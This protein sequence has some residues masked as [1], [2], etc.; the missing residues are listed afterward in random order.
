[1][2][3]RKFVPTVYE[4]PGP[5]ATTAAGD[6]HAPGSGYN[7]DFGHVNIDERQPV[8]ILSYFNSLVDMHDVTWPN[9]SE[10][11][12]YISR[13]DFTLKFKRIDSLMICDLLPYYQ[14]THNEP[15]YSS[16]NVTIQQYDTDEVRSLD[17]NFMLEYPVFN[18][19]IYDTEQVTPVP[20]TIAS[21]DGEQTGGAISEEPAPKRRRKRRKK[22]DFN[23]KGQELPSSVI[24]SKFMMIPQMTSKQVKALDEVHHALQRTWDSSEADLI[25]RL[26]NG[27]LNNAKFYPAD[28]RNYFKLFGRELGADKGRTEHETY[29][30][31]DLISRIDIFKNEILLRG[32][33]M[34]ICGMVFLILIAYPSGYATVSHVDSREGEVLG[35]EI[36]RA[37]KWFK[38]RGYTP[39]LLNFD[40]EPGVIEQTS[41][42]EDAGVE[43][44]INPHGVKVAEA[45]NLI[46]TIKQ[47]LR[48]KLA[49]L[50]YDVGKT[51]LVNL[52]IAAVA[53]TNLISKKTNIGMLSPHQALF[54]SSIN[55]DTMLRFSPNDYVE[56]SVDETINDVLTHRTISAI[57]LFA[58]PVNQS[59]WKFFNLKTCRT[60]HRHVDAAARRP[61]TAE[62]INRLNQIAELNPIKGKDSEGNPI[63]I[64]QNSDGVEIP[65]DLGTLDTIAADNSIHPVPIP[66]P[67]VLNPD[68]IR[69]DT[70]VPPET[71]DDHRLGVDISTVQ[72]D[73]DISS[74]QEDTSTAQDDTAPSSSSIVPVESFSSRAGIEVRTNDTISDALAPE[75]DL[76]RVNPN[77][78]TE[79]TR[80]LRSSYGRV[81]NKRYF[82]T[83]FIN[84]TYIDP[85][86]Y[87][88][89]KS[90]FSTHLSAA[91]ALKIHSD[92][93]LN[94]ITSEIQGMVDREVF[95]GV[96]RSDLSYNQQRK[97]IRSSMF[98]KEK[99][100]SVGRL[101]KLK[102]RLVAG[103][104]RQD[105]SIYT[106]DQIS[107]PTV[108][109]ISF[110]TLAA[111]SAAE[112]RHILTFDIGQAYLNAD[113]EGEVYMVL[114]RLTASILVDIDP[115]YKQYLEKNGSMLVKLSKA[116]YGC[117]ESAKL[118][119][120]HLKAT[121]I[122]LGYTVNPVD[123]CVFNRVSDSGA[124]S[125]VCFHVDD[126]FASCESLEDLKLLEKQLRK[127]F[128]HVEIHHGKVHEYLGMKLDFTEKYI[129]HITMQAYIKR[130]IDDNQITKSS[131]TPAGANL[132]VVDE[133]SEK[134]D[135]A[136]SD[137]FHKVT[138][139]LLYL[140]TR[141]RP[142]IL[143]PTTFLCSRV[144]SPTVEDVKKLTR[145]LMYLNRTPNLGIMIGGD[146]SGNFRLMTYADAS[147]ATHPDGMKSHSGILLSI[148]RGPVLV[149]SSK[150]KLVT[151][152]STEA[153]LV[154]LSDATS[155]SIHEL[156]FLKA[157]GIE[158][159]ANLMQDNTSTIKLAENGRSN[160]DRTRHIK[161]RYFFIKQF[162][163][164]GE[165]K[166]S[167]CPTMH[168]VADILTKPLQG[169]HFEILRDMLL[170]YTEYPEHAEL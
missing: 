39:R 78:S 53:M 100:D 147:F 108:S 48:G 106:S 24:E 135:K 99:F 19:V 118:W 160:S 31:P 55:Y 124:Q 6:Y 167:Y 152:S 38:A 105:K 156:Q 102:A 54:G 60:F 32:D 168:M 141:V 62:V 137:D 25:H 46:K 63:L 144:Q 134:L 13:L 110:F 70:M 5:V 163:D 40:S 95:V 119:Y 65:E 9:N 14:F 68:I 164:D 89:P 15:I 133:Y 77:G 115:S 87:D 142:D 104:N 162:L 10:M 30:S 107:S 139:Q 121:L 71:S 114:D 155:L 123:I 148:G 143:L 64:F 16:I 11:Q 75:S 127:E 116:L 129:C 49:T 26:Q 113:M 132:F 59:K 28:I 93:A 101:I 131:R 145:I 36:L 69:A 170:G 74:V 165:M 37:I 27:G 153:E 91:K 88:K 136:S 150:Q 1:M 169:E 166:I 130:L 96:W 18:P 45:E 85:S 80:P 97:I 3:N 20:S 146:K 43:C 122:K 128:K 117:I 67:P 92:V 8:N 66:Q 29:E 7:K 98:L 23:L 112:N 61:M 72:E 52:V 79:R 90:I 44:V 83:D 138:A 158:L 94:A 41:V 120:N 51:I 125:T 159:V 58:D 109:T 73:A 17:T 84:A 82:N 50:L 76:V 34:I 35:K 22:L 81:P 126:G 42:I 47:R 33:L 56:V 157:Q 151:K 57:P 140:G 2:N 161:I 21:T 4:N 103:G 149:K 154:A 12:V 111:I 86:G